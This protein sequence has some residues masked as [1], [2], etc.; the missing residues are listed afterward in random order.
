MTI[1]LEPNR[2]WSAHLAAVLGA[3]VHTASRPEELHRACLRICPTNPSWCSGRAPASPSRWSSPPATAH[4]PR[5][6]RGAA[7][8]AVDVE[9]M[10]QALRAG[11]REVVDARDTDAVRAA[12]ARSLEVSRQLTR[13]RAPR[14]TAEEARRSS[15]SSPPRAAAARRPWRPTSPSPW[16]RAAPAGL[17]DRP[18]PGLRRRRRSC[19]SSSPSAASPTRSPMGDRLD[20]TGAAGAA[21][22]V[23][24]RAGH[25]ARAGRAG[26]GGADRPGARRPRCSGSARRMFDFVVIDTPAH[27]NDHVLAALD[28]STPTSW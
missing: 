14:R 12:C 13:Q 4:P 26:R 22:P 17:P 9:T 16:P 21:H 6:R 18:R 3:G 15:P 23:R 2:Q 11:V 10:R 24:A 7:A 1:L 20:E 25:P 5:A 19:C 27:F 8:R 28:V